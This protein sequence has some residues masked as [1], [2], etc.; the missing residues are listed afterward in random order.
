MRDKITPTSVTPHGTPPRGLDS[1]PRSVSYAGRFGRMFRNLSPFEPGDDDL[2]TLAQTIVEKDADAEWVTF[3]P[4]SMQR[5]AG[6]RARASSAPLM[7][8]SLEWQTC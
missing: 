3:S 8:V 1:A 4:S 7:T 6:N 5:Q 2:I